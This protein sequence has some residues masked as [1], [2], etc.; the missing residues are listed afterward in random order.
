LNQI[1]IETKGLKKHFAIEKGKNAAVVHAVDGIDLSI[2]NGETFGLVGESGCGKTTV[3]KTILR[4]IEPTDGKIFFEGVDLLGLSKRE[5]RD[6]R[7]KMQ[8]VHQDPYASLNPAMTVKKIIGRPI[9]IHEM[10]KGKEVKEKVD[11]LLQAVNIDPGWKNRFPHEFSGGQR[12]RIAI[13][14]A[15]AL[16]PKF[17]VLDEP[18][19]SLD[20]SVQG[21][22]IN[23]L[24]K[25]QKEFRLTFLF[26]SHNLSITK[27]ISDKVGVMYVGKLA[28]MA[29]AEELFK[30]PLHPYTKALISAIPSTDIDSKS[31]RI[32]LKGNVPSPTNLPPGCR[33]HPRCNYKMPVCEKEEPKLLKVNGEHSAAC[34]LSN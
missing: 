26:I 5:L 19:S 6:F 7:I 27:L 33:F 10:A 3:G 24:I 16:N 31:Q 21:Q 34:F 14:R 15:L 13:A 32:I 12:Q 2:Q 22:I 1:L 8:M 28:E 11:A 23:L 9:E 25:L 30:N 4:L 29:T 20:V 18:T 17:I